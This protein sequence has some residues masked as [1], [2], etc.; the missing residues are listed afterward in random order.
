M[1]NK[2]IDEDGSFAVEYFAC[3]TLPPSFPP[4]W[5]IATNSTS[6]D[7]HNDNYIIGDY[8]YM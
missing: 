3:D 4:N 8:I 6:Y 1:L 7:I 2:R 5:P